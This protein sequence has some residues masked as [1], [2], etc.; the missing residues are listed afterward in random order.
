MKTEVAIVGGGPAGSASAMFLADKGIKSVIIEKE[1]FP[2][3]HIGESMIG[4]C[5]AV[6]RALGLEERMLQH[7]FPI[8]HG[9]TVY[10][11]EGKN[12]WFVPSMGRDANWNLFDRFTWQVR[13][14][15]FDKMMLDEAVT[16]GAKLI[17]GQ[18]AEPLIRDDESVRGVRV[19]MEDGGTEDLESE[20]LLD[21]S[22]QATFLA[23]SG[24]TGPKYRG[25]Y[26]RQI[27]IFSQV[28]N[29]VRGE[30]KHR[31]DTLIFYQQKYHWAWFIPL[32]E[33]IV[34]LGV[35]IPAAYF[36]EKRESK[37]D[38]L[39]RELHELNPEL[40]QRV[41]KVEL[42]EETRSIVNYSFQVRQFCGPGY[43][44]I[45]DAHR[46]ID[47]IF[48]FGL[49]QTIKEAQLAAPVV[50]D[51]LDGANRD[52]P[53]PFIEHQRRCDEALD[54]AEDA[55]DAFWEHPLAFALYTH[56]R[57]RDEM[58]DVL[59]GRVFERQ[60]SAAVV[61]MRKLLQ[62]DRSQDADFSLPMGSRFHPER[63]GIWEE[64]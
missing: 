18:A 21:C 27:A 56:M 61:A 41:P 26:D 1:T 37:R 19:H 24:V 51:Y 58:I 55:V 22:G 42:V 40:K 5:A 15:D 45:G 44:C 13:R 50:K 14:G 23:N 60:P 3:Y 17:R 36:A 43:I 7:K 57:Y 35:V 16:R 48:S 52:D 54:I 34:S 9:L 33:E 11:S 49:F 8:K 28:K 46:F 39:V 10:G 31:D 12:A 25:N 53:N 20:V 29:A 32:D 63:A 64:H 62:R 2:R 38:F 47:P 4:E 59:A 6:I 30:G